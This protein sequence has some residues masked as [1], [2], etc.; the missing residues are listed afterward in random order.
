MKLLLDTH[1]L[2]W[3]AEAD[4]RLSSAARQSVENPDN[5]V[6]FSLASIWEMAIKISLGK[7]K[8]SSRLHGTFQRTLGQHGLNEIPILF[9]HVARVASLPFHH[10]DPFDRLLIAQAQQENLTLLSHD[11]RLD[12]YGVPRVW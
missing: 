1:A 7:L 12:A 4:A 2:I 8:M 6:F 5:S 11:Q 9:E 10:R 3:L